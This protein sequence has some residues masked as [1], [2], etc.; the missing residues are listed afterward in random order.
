MELVDKAIEQ[1]INYEPVPLMSLLENIHYEG[2]FVVTVWESDNL[3]G[4]F[5]L[6]RNRSLMAPVEQVS[7]LFRNHFMSCIPLVHSEY[8]TQCLQAFW[9]WFN[10]N[11]RGRILRFNEILTSSHLGQEILQTAALYGGRIDQVTTT[12]RAC[13]NVQTGSYEDYLAGFTSSK[14]RN[15]L[16]RKLRRLEEHGSWRVEI[17]QPDSARLSTLVDLLINVEMKSWKQQS[18]SAIGLDSGLTSYIKTMAGY[19]ISKNR[20]VLALGYLDD[21]P[22]AGSYG[23]VNNGKLMIYKIG[24]DEAWQQYSVGQLL[25]LEVIKQALVSDHIHTIDSCA[26]PNAEMFNRCLPERQQ[27]SQY[28]IASTQT[29][30]RLMLKMIS[31]KRKPRSKLPN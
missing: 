13:G 27:L 25:M 5:P 20:L 6:Q 14:S 10:S 2:W 15:T 16:K 17:A 1:N 18:G 7:T 28:K 9:N 22:I 21:Q 11:S 31:G 4:L 19:A 29:V 8:Q 24:Y 12:D 30:A 26:E 3:I 23:L